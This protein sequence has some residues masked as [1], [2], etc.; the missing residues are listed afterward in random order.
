MDL[1]LL[2]EGDVCPNR[3]RRALHGLGGHLQ[4]GEQFHLLAAMVK[5]GVLS[6]NGLHAAHSRRGLRIF[7]VQFDVGRELAGRQCEHR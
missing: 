5:G 6:H 4:I 2:S 1:L 7:D 3:L